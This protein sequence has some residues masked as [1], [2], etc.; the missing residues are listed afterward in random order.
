MN[1]GMTK[2]IN[3][4]N[5]L[6]KA[7]FEPAN[8]KVGVIHI[9]VGNF[10]RAHQAVYFNNILKNA[11]SN[12]WGIAGIN[13]RKEQS[14]L[15]MDLK[16]SNNNYI[17]KTVSAAGEAR[18][19]EIKS[20][21][22]LYDW[23][24]NDR[25]IQHLFSSSNVQLVTTTVTESGYYFDKDKQL[26]ITTKDI[27]NDLNGGT[28]LTIFG[29]LAKGLRVRME[30]NGLPITIA[31]CDNIQENGI[32]LKHCFNQYLN[33]LGDEVLLDWV[34][35][36]TSF[37]SSMVDRITPKVNTKEL[38]KIQESFSRSEDCS[39]IS[40]DFIQW[41]IED[42]FSGK[43]P[44]LSSVG[45]EIVD[46]IEP[47]ENTKIRILNGGHTAL[48]YLG[49][50]QGYK[51]YDQALSDPELSNFFDSIQVKEIISS[52]PIEPSINYLDYLSTT[53]RRFGNQNLPDS[54]SRICMDG[55]SKFP[56]FLLPVIEWHLSKGETPE[57]SLKAIA[58]WYIFL[59]QVITNKVTFEY[60]EPKWSMLTPF[61]VE[62]G[63]LGF[64][65]DSELWGDIPQKYPD[66]VDGVIKEI[67]AM[68]EQY[69]INF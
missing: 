2:N 29:A 18:H 45:V 33:E 37:P 65:K 67:Q 17:L 12:N 14:K 31:C 56:I 51:T 30:S 32:M 15:I 3:E 9:G 1:K 62:G 5:S 68:K 44:P 58:S 54:L 24:I 52:L 25:E 39:V 47:Y 11:S 41:V 19:E 66:F 27:Q 21:I 34:S 42:K 36:N 26:K 60:V 10:H 6:V 35:K 28:P 49:V 69:Q 48:A 46:D 53:K 61:L 22:E 23:E 50:L 57:F 4:S 20:I 55:G 40:E 16:K 43:K 7:S 8:C 63:E 13:L 59:C 38:L 64:A